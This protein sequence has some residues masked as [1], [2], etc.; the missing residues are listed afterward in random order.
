MAVP[1]LDSGGGPPMLCRKAEPCSDIEE[2]M[3]KGKAAKPAP[4]G[5]IITEDEI[6]V[7]TRLVDSDRLYVVPATKAM[8]PRKVAAASLTD[9][10]RSVLLYLSKMPTELP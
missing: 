6:K 9:G 10:G 7:M 3:A 8:K 1:F 5:P 2:E 4:R